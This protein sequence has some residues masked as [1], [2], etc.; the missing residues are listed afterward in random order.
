MKMKHRKIK[1]ITLCF[2]VA[3]FAAALSSAAFVPST[4]AQAADNVKTADV[5]LIAGQSN[6]AGSTRVESTAYGY[7][8]SYTPKENVLFY[9][10][11]HKTIQGSGGRYLT[12]F[13]PVRHGCG[14]TDKHVGFELGMANILNEQPQYAGGGKKAVIFKSAAGGTSVFPDGNYGNFGNWYPKSLWKEDYYKTDYY[15]IAGFQYRTF[16]SVFEEFLERLG[17]QGYEKVVI[18]GLFWM[19]GE[20][21]RGDPVEYE[22]VCKVLFGDFRS[23]ISEITGEDYSDL[24]IYAGEISRT[25]GSA[26]Q[27]SVEANLGLISAQH[28]ISQS[29]KNV[30][31]APLKDYLIND[32]V[33]GKNTV[34]GSD[35]AHWN[36]ED[37]VSVGEEFMKIFGET[38][39][40]TQY[41]AE[42]VASGSITAMSKCGV[43]FSGKYGPNYKAGTE[44]L[45]FTVNTVPEFTLKSIAADGAELVLSGKE[46][47]G[48]SLAPVYIY[49]LN[50]P[51]EKV[52]VNA[53]FG[54]N[55]AYRVTSSTPDKTYGSAPSVKVIKNAYSGCRYAFKTYPTSS[56]AVYKMI[57]NGHEVYGRK[58]VTEYVFDNWE[59]EYLGDEKSLHIE[60]IYGEKNEVHRQLDLL[61]NPVKETENGGSCKSAVTPSA[62]LA[63]VLSALASAFIV[64]AKKRR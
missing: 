63:T 56:G 50:S 7:E 30:Y 52:T 27:A 4:E 44:K 17:L 53:E 13:G 32:I 45:R 41:F 28:R 55:K 11:A 3:V 43:I 39:G 5:Y 12:D 22:R 37:I 19:Q 34:L 6:A 62:M 47:D 21:D 8:L 16:M 42:V 18:K 46:F 10:G 51:G 36:Y 60:I 54:T 58:N 64:M 31:I 20:S 59:E 14:F 38:Y 57:I 49:E 24:P 9:G 26:D 33:N 61:D 25:F 48:D 2:A 15:N 29:M 40:E 35:S 1:I 23:D